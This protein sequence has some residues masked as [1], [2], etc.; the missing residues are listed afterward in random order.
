[1]LISSPYSQDLTLFLDIQIQILL[2]TCFVRWT[3]ISLLRTWFR[4][5]ININVLYVC[6]RGYRNYHY[7]SV[8]VVS[9]RIRPRCFPSA[10]RLLRA[11]A[12]EVNTFNIQV[13]SFSQLTKANFGKWHERSQRNF[14]IN[15]RPRC[16]ACCLRILTE[17][18][19]K[20]SLKVISTA[21]G[22]HAGKTRKTHM[23]LTFDCD[24]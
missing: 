20:P 4:R 17:T 8:L 23:T 2:K 13:H 7:A 24:I 10:F 11:C 6:M 19:L 14:L 18:I 21:R 3:S 16:N 12:V 15:C 9:H 5:V 1:M 22:Y